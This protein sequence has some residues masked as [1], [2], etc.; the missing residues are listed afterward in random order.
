MTDGI[1][2]SPEEAFLERVKS[3]R[4]SGAVL[5]AKLITLRTDFPEAI[6]LVF[7]GD[8]DKIVYGQ[9]IRRLRPNLRYEPFPCGGKKEV[10]GLKNAVLRDLNGLGQKTYF[11]V[12][13]DFDDLAGFNGTE[14][15]F[16]TEMYAVENYLVSKEVLEELL[17]DEFPCHGRPDKRADVINLF[18]ADYARFLD[19]TAALNRRIFVSRRIP[20]EL[21][22]RLPTSLRSLATIELG[23]IT[24]VEIELESIVVYERDPTSDEIVGLDD[25][26]ID[27]DPATRYRGK[28]ALK[29]FRDWLGK[30]ADECQ[31]EG[32]IIFAEVSGPVRRAEFVISNFA[33]KSRLPTGLHEFVEAIA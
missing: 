20:I 28:F 5:K 6:I 17:R 33:S 22:K 24:P 19:I 7:E 14:S 4:Q 1:A 3:S 8:D 2:P 31:K 16:M 11:F 26:F 30:L 21:K 15:V 32:T 10:R 27:L 12:D 18:D 25:Q 29:F 9:W 23:N 13:R